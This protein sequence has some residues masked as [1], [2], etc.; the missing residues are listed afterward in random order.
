[1]IIYLNYKKKIM[2][3]KLIIFQFHDKKLLLPFGMALAQIILNIIN[4]TGME[5][6]KNQIL[7]L[8]MTTFSRL[9]LIF[10]PMF[11]KTLFNKKMSKSI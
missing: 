10:V 8:V 2:V 9:S 7:E 6:S 3:K 1:M 11:T 4:S 5:S